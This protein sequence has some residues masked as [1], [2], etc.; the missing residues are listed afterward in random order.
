MSSEVKLL[1]AL[2]PAVAEP[3][4]ETRARARE[5][6]L[7]RI[8]A[9][10]RGRRPRWLR[11]RSVRRWVVPCLAVVGLGAAGVGLA[12]S[13]ENWWESA[14]PAVRPAD[15]EDVLNEGPAT[16]T[17]RMEPEIDRART[18]ARASGASLVAAPTEGGGYCL[19]PVPDEGKPIHTCIEDDL[20]NGEIDTW[21]DNARTDP[22]WYLLGRVVAERATRIELFER[23][24]HPLE[25]SGAQTLP[26][27]PLEA[28]VGPGGFFLVRVPR[29]LWPDLELAYGQMNVLDADGGVLER[30]CHYLGATKSVFAPEG[31]ASVGDPLEVEGKTGA[32][33]PCPETGAAVDRVP[34][35]QASPRTDDLTGVAGRD[36]VTGETIELASYLGRPLLIGAWDPDIP[37]AS[38]FLEALD[39]FGRRHPDVQ[40][41]SVLH[42]RSFRAEAKQGSETLGLG[43]P[44]ILVTQPF[45][46]PRVFIWDANGHFG[47]AVIALDADGR[48]AAELAAPRSRDPIYRYGML[49]QRAL[50][51][52]LAAAGG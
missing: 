11:G 32:S 27:T 1:T 34:L 38:R 21:V 48:I 20:D 30:S 31:I 24:T 7:S 9:D 42:D 35:L 36:V 13:L 4:P 50:E 26:G 14:G 37:T 44:T 33:Y 45:S 2:R 8:S 43:F 47:L 25:E 5:I 39:E 46:P 40:V 15:V 16:G 19:V 41:L 23:V 10:A 29:E 3:T 52:A 6:L 51:D 49:T 12:G 18:V 17:G 22:A 28:D